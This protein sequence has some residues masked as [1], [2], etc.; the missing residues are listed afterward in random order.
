MS[1]WPCTS[2]SRDQA[3]LPSGLQAHWNGPYVCQSC[4]WALQSRSALLGMS[5]EV[6][7]QKF[8][9]MFVMAAAYILA[10]ALWS[11]PVQRSCNG[12]KGAKME[13]SWELR[14]EG[15]VNFDLEQGILP[16]LVTVSFSGKGGSWTKQSLKCY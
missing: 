9:L 12:S 7:P 15:A 1:L 2:Y 8:I 5:T 4:P 3:H 11:F 16:L 13:K 14:W 6:L 10:A